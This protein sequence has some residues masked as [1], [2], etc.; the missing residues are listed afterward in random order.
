MAASA[1]LAGGRAVRKLRWRV[2]RRTPRLV[3][4]RGYGIAY[5]RFLCLSQPVVANGGC[6]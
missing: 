6:G 3:G 2:R 5:G 4:A 1:R